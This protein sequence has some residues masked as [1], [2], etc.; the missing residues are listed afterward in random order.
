MKLF[1]LLFLIAVAVSL[2]SGCDKQNDAY[3]DSPDD[4]QLKSADSRTI[5]FEM[6]GAYSAPIFC[7]G[8]LVDNLEAPE[9]DEGL[10]NLYAHATAH[11]KD[12][13]LV[14]CIVHA[15]GTF[16]SQLTGETYK[17]NEIDKLT[18]DENEEM[19]FIWSRTHAKGDMGTHVIMFF[20]IDLFAQTF[21]LVKGVCPQSNDE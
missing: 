17:I 5:N 3:L 21:D 12:G 19:T 6:A 18:F 14:W 8:E 11:I 15:K 13:K 2:L 20:N 4:L 16:K 1:K 10:E 7:D 9:G